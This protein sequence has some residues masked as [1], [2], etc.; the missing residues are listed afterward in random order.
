MTF[1]EGMAYLNYKLD[2]HMKETY[3]IEIKAKSCIYQRPYPPS[4]DYVAL[5]QDW[6]FPNFVKFSRDGD[7]TTWE[8][9]SQYLLN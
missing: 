3:G 8:H 1:D 2:K 4:F 5:P 6:K 7:R 9:V